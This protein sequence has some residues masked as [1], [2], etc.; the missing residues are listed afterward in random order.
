MFSLI[1]NPAPVLRAVLVAVAVSLLPS[2]DAPAATITFVGVEPGTA[3]SGYAVQNWSN[4][5]VA[6]E[7]DL[8]GNVYG[9]AGY[10]QIR[11][12]LNSSPSDVY[13]AVA[14]GNNLG[15]TAGTNPTLYSA[16]VFLS[17]ITG[18]AGT[19]VNF[20]G[21]PLFRGPD[22]STLYRQ[23]S[24]S[25]SVG[26]GLFNTPSG[27][28]TG[29]YGDAFSF[30]MASGFGANFRI[31]IAV[32]TAGT[33]TYAPDYVSIYNSGT[34]SVFSS[35][36]TRNGTPDMTVFD[37][38]ASAGESFAAAMWQLAGTQSVSP[39][40]LITFDVSRYNFD[41]G[42]GLSQTNSVS[43]GGAPA[44][45]LK[46]GA[47]TLVMASSN[48]A[49]GGALVS[50]GTLVMAAGSV[51]GGNIT[52]NS[53]LVFDGAH[54]GVAN[55]VSGTGSLVKS[56]AGIATFY[57]SN[58]YAGATVVSGGQLMLGGAGA[59]PTGSAVD[60]AS[61]ASIN[62]TGYYAPGDTNRTIGGLTGAGILYGGGGTVTINKSADTDT[63]SGDIQGGQGLIKSGAG[64]LALAGAS[65]Y[66]GTTFVN[67]GRL[68]LAHADALGATSGGTVVASGAQLR[69][70]SLADTVFAAE[71]LIISGA[72]VPSGGALR[73]ATN[74]NTWQGTITLAANATIGA[75]SGTTL[76]LMATNGATLD[77]SS[78]NLVVDGAGTVQVNGGIAGSGQISKI[79]S[80]QLVVSN[81]VL[82]ATILSNSASV[83][84]AA[85]PADGTFA[86][87]SGPLDS[88]SLASTSVTGLGAGQT[89]TLVN[90]PNLVVQVSTAGNGYD[91]W[92]GGQPASS[93]NQL[94]YAIGGA[95]G[96]T[97][98][99]GVASTTSVTSTNLS[100]TAIVRTNDPNLTVS[101]QSIT[102][103]ATGNWTNNDVTLTVPADQ[104]GATPGTTQRQTFSTPLGSGGR[105]FLRLNTTLQP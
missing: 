58:S 90:A 22:G 44:G 48:S 67:E 50:G 61:G 51:I 103:L 18:G 29:Y 95:S 105:K 71:P 73:N 84:F 69:I 30:T 21:Y 62:L 39:F 92:L 38:S 12:T 60:I 74:N 68:V 40:G 72:G 64:N 14:S 54:G 96:P 35:L 45:V 89:G 17:S 46:T 91:T 10:Y 78:F 33:G 76:T 104:T 79:G 53:T 16:P 88:A 5:G 28:N 20:G 36:L 19:Y 8:S 31:G 24:L 66:T 85:A 83:H 65:S 99:N 94:A 25:V 59:I 70:N 80:G 82:A 42:S 87:L 7:F 15:I 81:S 100:I 52:N 77:L 27:A 57:A 49:A 3:G 55:A 43:L 37:V 11:P 2:S 9:T 26:N 41:V 86:V 102:N 56:G 63:F 23:G 98:T 13:E 97:A 101:G 6:K 34:G 32:D 93:A 75:G 47:G 4:A 1:P